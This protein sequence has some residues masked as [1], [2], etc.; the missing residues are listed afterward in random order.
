MLEELETVLN[1]LCLSCAVGVTEGPQRQHHIL[2]DLTPRALKTLK[3]VRA[4]N[5]LSLVFYKDHSGSCVVDQLEA[6]G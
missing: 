6:R 1:G 5:R 3:G 2:G 4:E